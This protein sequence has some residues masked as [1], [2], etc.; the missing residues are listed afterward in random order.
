MCYIKFVPKTTGYYDIYSYSN[1]D[2]SA[3]LYDTYGRVVGFSG[4]IYTDSKLSKYMNTKETPIFRK[5]NCLYFVNGYQN[6][7][8]MQ[9]QNDSYVLGSL[10][11]AEIDEAAFLAKMIKRANL[12]KT[13]YE[14]NGFAYSISKNFVCWYAAKSAFDLGPKGIRVVS[15]SPGLIATDMGNLENPENGGEIY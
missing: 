6:A 2:P 4:R 3:S 15:L 10:M 12:A 11:I 14:K 5:G 7:K 13:D 9:K 8:D 1:C